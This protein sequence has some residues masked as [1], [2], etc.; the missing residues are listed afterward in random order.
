[1]AFHRVWQDAI[2][3]AGATMCMVQCTIHMESSCRIPSREWVLQWC[4]VHMGL[5]GRM[6]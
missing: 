6:S 5:C 2:D 4:N 1:M 3:G